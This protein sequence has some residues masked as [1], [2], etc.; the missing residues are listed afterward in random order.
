MTTWAGDAPVTQMD[1]SETDE[2]RGLL[3]AYED[4][5]PFELDFQDF[6][7]ELAELPGDYAPPRGALLVARSDGTGH[8]LRC[9]SS[10]DGRRV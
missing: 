7:R 1:E 5:L 3:R 10:A 4:S 8:R 9:P 6:N 2:V